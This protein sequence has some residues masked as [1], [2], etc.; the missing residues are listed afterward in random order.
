MAR[1]KTTRTKFTTEMDDFIR[2]HADLRDWHLADLF[3]RQF[4]TDI[5]PSA[6]SNRR[7]NLRGG[8]RDKAA[9]SGMTDKRKA[10]VTM[11]KLSILGDK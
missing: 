5:S 11:P 9:L 10:T 3:N 8:R 2:E 7:Q 1:T 4:G 6:A